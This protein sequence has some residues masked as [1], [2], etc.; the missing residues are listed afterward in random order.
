[1]FGLWSTER[2]RELE[3]LF[4]QYIRPKSKG[5]SGLKRDAAVAKLASD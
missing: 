1:M 4:N 5:G 3:V 2:S